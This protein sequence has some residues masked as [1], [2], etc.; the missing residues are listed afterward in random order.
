MQVLLTTTRAW[1]LGQTARPF[2]QRNAL[3]GLWIAD[4]NATRIPAQ[5]YR[6]CVPYHVAMKPFYHLTPENWQEWA[7]YRLIGFWRFWL[8][9]N[10]KSHSCPKFD[11]AQAILGFGEELFEKAEQVGALKVADCPNSHPI[12][13][14]HEWQRE[15]D[16]WCPGR[17]VPIPSWMFARMTRELARADVVLCPSE[18]VRQSMVNN[19][20]P[21]SKCFLNSY[22]VNTTLFAAKH[23]NPSPLA[24]PRFISV[25][26]ISLRKGH[27]YLFRAF[28]QVKQA[29]PQAELICVGDYKADF[30]KERPRWIGRFRH[31]PK[32]SH[33]EL[34]KLLP[35]C[36]AFALMSVE[37]GFA[38]AIPEAMAAGLPI[39]ATF[40]TGATSLVTDGVEG[41]IVPARDPDKTAQALIQL[42]SDPA[43]CRRMGD[44]ARQKAGA[45]NSW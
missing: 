37:E 4:K 33:P 35:T 1:H 42:A 17:K 23:N 10:L 18:F 26:A 14:Q 45:G 6:R 43:D 24:S 31:Y 16:L 29:L 21:A 25:G 13:L 19:G 2:S 8:Q 32:L 12:T 40:Q 27:Q 11:A 7:T 39:V 28:E 36:T 3:A 30:G 38:R 41:K 34:A 22:G 15:C 9:R 44:A 20:V 5:L